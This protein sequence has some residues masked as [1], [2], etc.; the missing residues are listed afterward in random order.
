MVH[1]E[2]E[3]TEEE[4]EEAL[5]EALKKKTEKEAVIREQE[6]R[7]LIE[8]EIRRPWSA[9]E[10]FHFLNVRC[11]ELDVKFQVD[12]TNHDVI[13]ALCKYFTNDPGF[14]KMDPNWKL[15]KGILL[16]GNVG[17]GKTTIMNLFN[18]NKKACYSVISC[19]LIADKFASMGSEV[20]HT[21][22]NPLN[23]PY[24]TRTFFQTRIGVCFDDLGTERLGKKYG[25]TA[26]VMEQILLNR[27][28]R[29]EK[30]W[31][32]VHITTNLSADE[33]EQ[34]YGTRVKSRMRE[35]FNIITLNG[36]DRRQ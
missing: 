28:D 9:K 26:N 10:M 16:Y 6:E 34:Y 17:T 4:K 8:Q 33:I 3:L 24:S 11:Q 23:V 1:S 12:E 19:R 20:L 32:M 31:H 7:K 25:E 2:V 35:M 36:E 15:N 22:A 21:Y 29:L 13:K 14:E 18:R 27:Y 30:E 5:R